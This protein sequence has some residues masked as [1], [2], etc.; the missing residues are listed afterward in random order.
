MLNGPAFARTAA[1]LA[2]GTAP[3]PTLEDRRTL[4]LDHFR[5]LVERE[6]EDRAMHKLRTFTGWYGL[7]LPQGQQLRRKI[8]GLRQPD[9]FFAA[10]DAHFASL[11]DEAA[12]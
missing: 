5:T 9:D 4:I 7:G 6:P 3:E 1:R 10:V 2:G 11:R 12:A 8:H